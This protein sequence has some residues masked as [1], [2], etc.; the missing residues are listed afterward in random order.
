VT[1]DAGDKAKHFA[2]ADTLIADSLNRWLSDVDRSE[3]GFLALPL[4]VLAITDALAFERAARFRRKGSNLG[5]LDMR[6]ACQ[7][8]L[9]EASDRAGL[10]SFDDRA[11]NEL[12]FWWNRTTGTGYYGTTNFYSH[13]LVNAEYRRHI[14]AVVANPSMHPYFEAGIWDTV[15]IA[16]YIEES[17]DASMASALDRQGVFA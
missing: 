15:A 10:G 4:D 11:A 9:R 7:T 3:L 2:D 12:D 1:D 16:R 5:D 14:S 6:I 8:R 13:P 17:I